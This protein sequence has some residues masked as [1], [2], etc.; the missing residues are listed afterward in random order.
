MNEEILF[1]A[2][3]ARKYGYRPAS[4]WRKVH[5]NLDCLMALERVGYN[6]YSRTL[7]PLEFRIICKYFGY[8]MT[9]QELE[10]ND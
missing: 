1:K 2:D 6:K 10:R 9:E 7:S 5:Q 4:F 8:P 3:M